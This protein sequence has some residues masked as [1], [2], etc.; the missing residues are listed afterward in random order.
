MTREILQP[1]TFP[2]DSNDPLTPFHRITHE[3]L[4]QLPPEALAGT[5]RPD[6][7]WHTVRRLQRETATD[8]LANLPLDAQLGCIR[9]AA[10][11][12]F[13]SRFEWGWSSFDKPAQTKQQMAFEGALD[14]LCVQILGDSQ[15]EGC[16]PWRDEQLCELVALPF[17]YSFERVKWVTLVFRKHLA[18][19]PLHD[20]LLDAAQ[21]VRHW[22]ARVHLADS[23]LSLGR[24]LGDR[25][26]LQ[27]G[28]PWA[29]EARAWIAELPNF[30]TATWQ[31]FLQ[32]CLLHSSKSKPSATW[33]RGARHRKVGRRPVRP[34]FRR[35]GRPLGRRAAPR[36][37]RSRVEIAGVERLAFKRRPNRGGA[38][39]SGA[40]RRT[41]RRAKPRQS[42]HKIASRI[43]RQPLV[44]EPKKR[45][46]AG[47]TKFERR[48]QA[49]IAEQ[50]A[51]KSHC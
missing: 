18:H 38:G 15:L 5:S 48:N 47:F 30:Q 43:Q 26:V 32:S 7:D 36:N 40:L 17:P 25:L 4:A 2:L 19:H 20:E 9:A 28:E 44:A 21:T 41:K 22:N 6:T 31:N 14:F 8:F 42:P 35:V 37:Q 10:R 24:V 39:K 45:R 3:F 29:D 49:E 13:W 11:F 16:P 12:S 23:W 27:R 50:L 1:T 33:L 34:Q 51:R 46:S